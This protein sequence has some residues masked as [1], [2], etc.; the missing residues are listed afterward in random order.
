MLGKFTALY[1]GQPFAQGVD[2]HNVRAAGQQL[3]GDVI[4]FLRRDQGLF[5][6]RRAAA[7]QQKQDCIR[8]LQSGRHGQ[9]R[10]RGVVGVRVGHRMP[11]FPDRQIADGA[12]GVAV[13]G[14]DDAVVDPFPKD[15]V[16]GGGHLP[17]G[18][19]R[20]HKDESARSVG[21]LRQR[22]LHG[23]IRQRRVQC[24]I[25]YF[26]GVLPDFLVFHMHGSCSFNG[27]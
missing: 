9:G 13:F 12:H 22:L 24:R 5:K 18:L 6:Q 25:H 1:G 3:P 7:G 15:P 20:G 2:L 23:G 14:D 19:A 8:F 16:R 11:G 4:H 27:S 21:H 10:F 17:R 26:P